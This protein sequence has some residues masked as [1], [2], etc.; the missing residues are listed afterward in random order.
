M[1][2]KRCRDCGHAVSTSARRCPNCGRR[3]GFADMSRGGK[4]AFLIG[5]VIVV[6]FGRLFLQAVHDDLYPHES[7]PGLE[8]PH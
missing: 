2:I 8:A 4:I 5:F 7:P 1:S 6:V 3:R